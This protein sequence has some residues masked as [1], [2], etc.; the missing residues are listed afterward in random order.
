[1]HRTQTHDNSSS[2]EEEDKAEWQ[3]YTTEAGGLSISTRQRCAAHRQQNGLQETQDRR[4]SQRRRAGLRA[5]GSAASHRRVEQPC[6]RH[7]RCPLRDQLRCCRVL[8]R[9]ATPWGHQRVAGRRRH[10]IVENVAVV[11]CLRC[12][13]DFMHSDAVIKVDQ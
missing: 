7:D 11:T 13:S 3:T 1:M 4:R 9:G 6:A 10:W 2:W 8:Q 5:R 12:L